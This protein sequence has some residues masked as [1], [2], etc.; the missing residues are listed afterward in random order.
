MRTRQKSPMYV[1][2][3]MQRISLAGGGMFLGLTM[4]FSG[5][6][7]AIH[8]LKARPSVPEAASEMFLVGLSSPFVR[9]ADY[10]T[11]PGAQC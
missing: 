5:I 8:I 2:G 7:A 3:E 9:P 11:A 6:N 1:I 4:G 10:L